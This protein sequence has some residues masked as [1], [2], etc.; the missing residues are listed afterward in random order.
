MNPNTTK[1][2][3]TDEQWREQR[4]GGGLTAHR[5]RPV[6]DSGR[7]TDSIDEPKHS[8]LECRAEVGKF[9]AGAV[10]RHRVLH[11]IVG[12][13]AEEIHFTREGIGRNRGA[14]N[15]DH[16]ADFHLAAF[17]LANFLP[18]FVQDRFGVAQFFETG[19]HRKHDLH[20]ADCARAQDRA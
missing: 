7:A 6:M 16:R 2:V 13:N 20:V 1:T 14:R 10:R 9:C 17:F 4:A 11:Q 19:N 8:R 15:L 12:A 5:D 3:Q 18:A